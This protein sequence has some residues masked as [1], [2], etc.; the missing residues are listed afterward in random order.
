[1]AINKGTMRLLLATQNKGKQKEWRALLNRLPISIVLPDALGLNM[2]IEETGKTYRENAFLKAMA[3]TSASGYPTL[4]DDSGL[5]VDAL[6]G[7][8]GVRSARF[9]LG[10]DKV[11]YQALLDAMV[12]VPEPERSARFRCIATLVVPEGDRY[13][14]EGVC[15]GRISLEP[16]GALG[17]GYDPVFYVT[18]Y[19]LTIA[20]LS[21][22]IKNQIS[23]RARAAFKMCDVLE[24]V[25]DL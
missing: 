18:E 21:Q 6:D 11:R 5:E 24:R 12:G 16:A 4:A 3:Y 23:H 2:D 22:D 10:S 17:F 7:A 25:F 1:M 8:P 13:D 15:E 20:Q 9:R 14:T 19:G